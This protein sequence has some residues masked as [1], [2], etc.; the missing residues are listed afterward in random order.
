MERVRA[1]CYRLWSWLDDWAQES[2]FYHIEQF[3]QVF[4]W[5]FKNPID[6]TTL[7]AYVIQNIREST[8]YTHVF[9][10]NWLWLK[11]SELNELKAAKA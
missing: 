5:L 4:F 11:I 6:I 9:V 2:T 8:Q 7:K 3:A 1:L 10:Q